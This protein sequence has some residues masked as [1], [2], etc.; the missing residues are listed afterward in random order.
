MKISCSMHIFGCCS[1]CSSGFPVWR[2][3]R[4]SR[5]TLRQ[6]RLRAAGFADLRLAVV[7][8][9]VDRRHGTE[10]ALAELLE[11]LARDYGCEVHLYA[12]RVEGLQLSDPRSPRPSKSGAI[13]W[14][15]VPSFPGPHLVQFLAWMFLNGSLRRWHKLVGGVSFDL[16]LSPGINC[17]H[18]DVVIVHAL[19]RRLQE[20]ARAEKEAPAAQATFLK[21]L[22]RRVYYS[23]LA[24]L[25][26]K[27]YSNKK[28][29]LAAVSQRTAGLLKAY[30]HRDDVRVIPN[31]VDTEHF[32]A[33]RG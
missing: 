17:L 7:S 3:R 20:L 32:A 19:F 5:L 25:E 33:A 8:P 12:Q 13:F 14:R 4:S 6:L 24:A 27:I 31:G 18:P 15:K 23:L 21:R 30:F 9:F 29:F 22:H 16:V 28:I 26:R 1:V 11:R 10:R 2:S